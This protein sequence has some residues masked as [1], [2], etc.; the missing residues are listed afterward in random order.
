[1]EGGRGGG[2]GGGGGGGDRDPK[3]N[4]KFPKDNLF[5]LVDLLISL[6]EYVLY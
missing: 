3:D 2:G 6:N 1:M 4:L 5:V